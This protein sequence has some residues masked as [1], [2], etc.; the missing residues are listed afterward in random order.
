MKWFRAQIVYK[1]PI[2]LISPISYI[3]ILW[4]MAGLFCTFFRSEKYACLSVCL[5]AINLINFKANKIVLPNIY[6]IWSYIGPVLCAILWN[7]SYFLTVT[8]ILTHI[9]NCYFFKTTLKLPTL[10]FTSNTMAKTLSAC[11]RVSF[12][13]SIK[14]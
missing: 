7:A 13:Y 9:K 11:K 12:Q 2:I 6:Y 10:D 5:S 14:L 4:Y 3:C 8:T 1:F